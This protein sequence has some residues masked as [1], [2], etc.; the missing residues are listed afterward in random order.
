VKREVEAYRAQ[1]EARLR[2]PQPGA[3]ALDGITAVFTAA[4]SWLVP[5]AELALLDVAK[6]RGVGQRVVAQRVVLRGD[7]Q[8]RRQASQA[9]R[10]AGRGIGVH[11][12]RHAAQV[13]APAV[14]TSAA[15][16]AIAGVALRCGADAGV[17]HG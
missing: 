10:C 2:A 14:G 6:A 12:I 11:R 8:G 15:Q 13:G 17:E 9:Q 4:P 3:A 7:Q 16:G 1:R 5:D